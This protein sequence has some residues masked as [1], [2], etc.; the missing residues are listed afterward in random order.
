[1]CRFKKSLQV[2][3]GVEYPN[4]SSSYYCMECISDDVLTRLPV[5]V[6]INE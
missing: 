4:L 1:M 2:G 5:N 3:V 6:A